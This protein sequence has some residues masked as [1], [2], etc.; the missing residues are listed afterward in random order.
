MQTIWTI[1]KRKWELEM[2]SER[3]EVIFLKHKTEWN[4][5]QDNL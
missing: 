2:E 5:E 1:K 3:N 4:R